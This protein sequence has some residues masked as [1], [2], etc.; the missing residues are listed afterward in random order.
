VS[1]IEYFLTFLLWIYVIYGFIYYGRK[2]FIQEDKWLF[3]FPQNLT[4]LQNIDDVPKTDVNFREIFTEF[5][6]I[7]IESINN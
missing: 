5:S 2:F 3:D 1:S 7:E 4:S 6:I